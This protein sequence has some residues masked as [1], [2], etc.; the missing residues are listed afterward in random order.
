MLNASLQKSEEE[1]ELK[2]LEIKKLNIELT[3]AVNTKN[4]EAIEAIIEKAI[5]KNISL[6]DELAILFGEEPNVSCRNLLLF[7]TEIGWQ[8]I[9]MRL[10]NN[11][12][13][14]NCSDGYKTPLHF[15]SQAGNFA[16]VMELINHG[17]DPEMRDIHGHT[18]LM[19]AEHM[20]NISMFYPSSLISVHHGTPMHRVIADYLKIV[21]DRKLELRRCA[22]VE[23][24]WSHGEEENYLAW[25]PSEMVTATNQFV[26]GVSHFASYRQTCNP[27]RSIFDEVGQEIENDRK[28]RLSKK[29][30]F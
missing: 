9:F 27:L 14:A 20:K 19:V 29:A 16:M 12:A 10:L 28:E 6:D 3:Q 18:P 5:E 7:A 21:K 30:A 25:L 11:G 23:A 1:S 24:T 15:A 22:T 26:F 8:R 4:L 13:N 2:K 17:A